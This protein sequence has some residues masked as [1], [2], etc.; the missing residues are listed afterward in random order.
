MAAKL[1]QVATSGKDLM[2]FSN[3]EGIFKQKRL[4]FNKT[5]FY[6]MLRSLKKSMLMVN[7]HLSIICELLHPELTYL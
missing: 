1:E 4:V 2:Y 5:L 6:F 7:A 3:K